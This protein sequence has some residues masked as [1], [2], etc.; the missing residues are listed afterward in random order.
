MFPSESYETFGRVIVEAFSVGT[1]VLSS[2]LGAARELVDDGRTGRL[3]RA[4]DPG[5]LARLISCARDHPERVRAK[6]DAARAEF[7]AKYTAERNHE[8]LTGIYRATIEQVR[9]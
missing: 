5:D 1:P 4:G 2:D 6:R 7:E 9:V 8:L 3:F